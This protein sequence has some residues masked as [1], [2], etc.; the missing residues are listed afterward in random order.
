M[1]PSL[2]AHR[3]RVLED[4]AAVFGTQEGSMDNE[5]GF[6]VTEEFDL[7]GYSWGEV[8]EDTIVLPVNSNVLFRV[9]NASQRTSKDGSIKSVTAELRLVEGV[10]VPKKDAAGQLTG[11][12]EIKY[13]NKPMF[14]DLNYWVDTTVR[15]SPRYTSPN[16]SYLMPLK[17]FLGA[18]GYDPQGTK[19]NDDFYAAIKGR[20]IRAD[21]TVREVRIKNPVTGEWQG[22]GEHRNE[23]R[24]FRAV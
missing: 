8:K 4:I 21:I 19:L 2:I 11:E 14:V 12:S 22:T 13:V 24:K 17:Q 15:N 3:K 16:K 20:E 18:L 23:I 10:Q 7:G 5:A 1:E 9:Q 6:Q